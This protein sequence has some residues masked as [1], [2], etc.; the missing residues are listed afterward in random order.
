MPHV[1]WPPSE[2]AGPRG[3]YQVGTDAEGRF[4][5]DESPVAGGRIR[6]IR[7][8]F[9]SISRFRVNPTGAITH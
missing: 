8:G 5:W 7:E 2:N 1:K 4:Q 9:E 3:G 6:V